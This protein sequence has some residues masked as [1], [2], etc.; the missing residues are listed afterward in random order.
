VAMY[1][2]QGWALWAFSV[3][4]GIVGAAAVPALGV[5]GP[6]LFATTAR[7]RANGLISTLGVIG[8]ALGLLIVGSLSD[9]EGG[10][11]HA[12]PYVAIGPL[13]L[14]VLIVVAYPETAHL[15]LEELNPEDR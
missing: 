1:L 7:G 10:V 8:S 12:M 13:L 14:A 9:R 4:G 11:G 6:E 5:Y 2:S 15:E 3:A